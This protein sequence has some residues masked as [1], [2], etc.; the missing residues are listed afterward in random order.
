M[1][2]KFIALS[3]EV[4]RGY[5]NGK[6]DANG[7]YPES[8][9]S[10]GSGNPCRHC[11]TEIAKGKGML[12]LAYR[13]ETNINPY[14]EVGPIFLCSDECQRHKETTG[15]PK[16]F[17][18]WDKILIRGYSEEGRIVYGT[19]SVINMSNVSE[20]AKDMFEN[21]AVRYINLRSASYNCYQCRIERK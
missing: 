3:T 6:S 17:T 15:L 16:M 21:E 18:S 19:G 13:P 9:I 10:D 12:I 20:V 4:V 14:A 5:Q 11:F 8:V 2:I 1:N 7:Q